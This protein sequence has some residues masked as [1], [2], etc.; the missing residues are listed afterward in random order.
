MVRIWLPCTKE[1]FFKLK[2]RSKRPN[3]NQA[4]VVK[5]CTEHGNLTVNFL[6]ML[7]NDFSEFIKLIK[8][9]F[10]EKAGRTI[11]PD[12]TQKA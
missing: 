12:A 8:F 10:G 1:K 4:L 6:K 5:L 3:C 2:S 7:I 9:F 11:L